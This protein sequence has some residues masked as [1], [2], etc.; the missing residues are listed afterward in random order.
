ME[1]QFTTDE[2]GKIGAKDGATERPR[3]GRNP[4]WY[5][6][7]EQARLSYRRAQEI[8]EESTRLP[9]SPLAGPEDVDDLEGALHE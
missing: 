8:F 2:R 5:P 7:T 4:A 9:A 1:D 6:I 3:R